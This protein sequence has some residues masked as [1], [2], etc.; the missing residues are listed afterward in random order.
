MVYERGRSILFHWKRDL[1]IDQICS[2]IIIGGKKGGRMRYFRI[3]GGRV[4]KGEWGV[5]IPEQ[6]PLQQGEKGFGDFYPKGK[7]K[8]GEE[9]SD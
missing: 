8:H 9:S 4:G 3:W 5:L 7:E 1:I 2:E 6:G